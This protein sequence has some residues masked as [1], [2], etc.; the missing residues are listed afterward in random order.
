MSTE[1]LSIYFR[2]ILRRL[3][4]SQLKDLGELEKR[5]LQKMTEVCCDSF[6]NSFF[7][8]YTVFYQVL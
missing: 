1:Q 8:I 6:P 3:S 4:I 7:G 5:I 2:K